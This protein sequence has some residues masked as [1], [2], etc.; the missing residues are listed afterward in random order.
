MNI[1]VNT[2][3]TANEI[4]TPLIPMIEDNNT[5]IDIGNTKPSRNETVD[6]ILFSSMA[7]V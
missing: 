6:D 7:C 1:I 4:H 2:S 5:A 3:D